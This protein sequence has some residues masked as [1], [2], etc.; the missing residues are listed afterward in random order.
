MKSQEPRFGT[1]CLEDS[2]NVLIFQHEQLVNFYLFY[3]TVHILKEE[4]N[5]I[6]YNGY[7]FSSCSDLFSYFP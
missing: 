5:T 4:K 7:Q 6:W 1:E 2:K 3:M